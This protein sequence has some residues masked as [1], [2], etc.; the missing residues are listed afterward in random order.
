MK[1]TEAMLAVF[2]AWERRDV[3]ALGALFTDD[4]QYED[5]LRPATVVGRDG[6]RNDY[7]PSLEGLAECDITVRHSVEDGDIAFCEAY[8][9][10]ELKDG[11]RLDFPFTAVVEMRDG[12]IARIGEFFDTNPLTP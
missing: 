10:A 4:A 11:G 5:P 8:F 1:P 6:I 9:A 7:R 12:K 3:E 2:D